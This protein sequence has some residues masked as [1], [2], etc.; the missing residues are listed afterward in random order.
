MLLFV[1]DHRF[2][3]VEGKCYSTGGLD[4]K[5]IERYLSLDDNVIVYARVV[6]EDQFENRWS[7]I[8][9]RVR[10]VGDNTLS[11]SGLKEL[12]K[13]ADG[14]IVRLPSFLGNRACAIAHALNKPYL[15]EMVGCAWD[16]L[17]NHGMI[18]KMIAP[19][20]YVLTKRNVYRASHV[21]YVTERFLQNRYPTKGQVMSCSDVAI[22]VNRNEVLSRRLNRIN[23]Q[24]QHLVIG[25]IGA[26]DVSYKGQAE[27]IK[28]LGILKGRG[29]ARFEYQL[30]GN[31]N[32]SALMQVV[33]ECHVFKQV[34]FVGGVP[35]EEIN[36]W[37]DSIDVYIQPSR[38]E[39]L[40]RAVIEAQGRGLPCFGTRVGGIPELLREDAL[41]DMDKNVAKTIAN[42]LQSITATKEIELAMD[43]LAR[44]E[45]FNSSCLDER[46]DSFYRS[47]YS[48]SI[49][50]SGE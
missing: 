23:S 1:H 28:A 46:R 43:N 33:N 21:L 14:I 48:A 11:G 12:V 41:F 42:L 31:G 39:G 10:I 20:Y 35:H 50:C 24:R 9:S 6:D 13:Q 27:V 40:P 16:S 25:T 5:A 37:L 30:V 15:V 29:D 36:D 38:T 26:V 18:G 44:A 7:L 34:S 8:S 32:R 49:G 47:F 4:N 19:C 45:R 3:R 22:E 17:V 2:R